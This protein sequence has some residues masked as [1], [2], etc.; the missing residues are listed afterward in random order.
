MIKIISTFICILAMFI[1]SS[2]AVRAVEDIEVQLSNPVF[3]GDSSMN[4]LLEVGNN[5]DKKIDVMTI[6]SNNEMPAKDPTLVVNHTY[7]FLGSLDPYYSNFFKYHVLVRGYLLTE[8]RYVQ[9]YVKIERTKFRKTGFKTYR[10][11]LSNVIDMRAYT[12][13]Y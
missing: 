5:S 13:N 10:N 2:T 1:F 4:I 12:P 3:L 6:Y 9:G 11:Y 8:F 7:S